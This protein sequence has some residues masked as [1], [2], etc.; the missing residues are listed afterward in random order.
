MI[1]K[2]CYVLLV[3]C[4]AGVSV[5]AAAQ[6]RIK[7]KVAALTL[8]VFNPIIVS[9]MREKGIDARHGLEMDVKPYPSIAAFYA[10]LA[11]RHAA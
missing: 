5:P 1:V 2:T 6:D 10:A 4:L 7:L 9:L 8:P 11:E 3:A